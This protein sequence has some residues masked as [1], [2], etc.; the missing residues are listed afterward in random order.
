[1]IYKLTCLP[2]A[3]QYRGQTVNLAARL[4]QRDTQPSYTMA[5]AAG[6]YRP[7]VDFFT[8]E[9]VAHAA[10]QKA[11]NTADRAA[12]RQY[13]TMWPQGYNRTCGHPAASKQVFWIRKNAR[14]L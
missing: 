7:L 14:T 11:A 5:R 4:R 3:M 10:S 9:V 12:I 6:Q 8:V 1:M 2:T 13:D